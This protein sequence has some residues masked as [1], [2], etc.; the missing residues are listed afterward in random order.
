[1]QADA[2]ATMISSGLSYREIGERVG[3][4]GSTVAYWARKHG[5]EAQGAARFRAKGPIARA[6]LESL[7]IQGLTT[8]Q[9]A[10]RTQ[11][12][13]T[14]VRHWLRRYGLETAR[15][16][17]W[18]TRNHQ[19]GQPPVRQL[20]CAVHGRTR[21]VLEG[22]GRYRCAACRS[23]G[24]TA[25]RRRVKEILVAEGGGQCR[26]CGYRRF[27]G[28]LQ[29]HHLDPASKEFA[30]SLEGVTL[31]LDRVRAEARK[32]VLLCANCH[33]EV[34]AGVAVVGRETVASQHG[35]SPA[36]A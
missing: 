27:V 29:F 21:F 2:L 6:T 34:E 11:R 28:A 19:P 7:V 36:D 4:S 26:L 14:T 9:I 10:E 15:A 20:E 8:R 35:P 30:I 13:Q 23:E 33:A 32:C 1:M 17:R 18:G 3:L 25:R 5:L 16:S 22:R 24:V 12:S 31:S